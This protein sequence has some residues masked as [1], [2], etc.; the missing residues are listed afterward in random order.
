[1]SQI[2]SGCGKYIW[3]AAVSPAKSAEIATVGESES[4]RSQEYRLIEP[5]SCILIPEIVGIT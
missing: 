1:M 4:V 3:R 5:S 2:H